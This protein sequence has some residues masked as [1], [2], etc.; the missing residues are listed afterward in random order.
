MMIAPQATRTYRRRRRG[1]RGTFDSALDVL[2]DSSGLPKAIWRS[3]VLPFLSNNS[4]ALCLSSVSSALLPVAA[5][6]MRQL[7]LRVYEGCTTESLAGLLLRLRGEG[8]SDL[9]GYW[10]GGGMSDSPNFQ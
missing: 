3:S 7:R 2:C 8:I 10:G 5:A 1:G 4:D 9:A 6:G